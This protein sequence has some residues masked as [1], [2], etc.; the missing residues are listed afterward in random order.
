MKLLIANRGEIALRIQ[1]TCRVLGIPTVAIGSAEE[2]NAQHV[3]QA[4][5]FRIL[6]SGL[7]DSYLDGARVLRAMQ[8]TGADAVHPGY[9]FLSENPEFVELVEGAGLVFVGPTADTMRRLGRKDLAKQL[10]RSL[11][12]PVAKGYDGDDQNDEEFLEHGATIGFPLMV[13]AVSGGGGRGLRR[14]E[15]QS[16]MRELLASA[17]REAQSGFGDSRLL[18]EEIIPAGR[19][20]EVQ[21]LGDGRGNVVHLFERECSVQRR[22][23]KIVE[24][25]PAYRLPAEVRRAILESAI[26]LSREVR[27]RSAATVEFLVF[28]RTPESALEPVFLE[29]NPRLQ[30]EHPVTEEVT[31]YDIVAQQIRIAMG[32]GELPTQDSVGVCGH[33][34]EARIYAEDPSQGFTPS[35]GL[36]RAWLAPPREG[37]ADGLRVESAILTGDEI[38]TSFD[39]MIAKI[40]TRGRDRNEAI[41]RMQRALQLCRIEGFA[42]NRELLQHILSSSQFAEGE[43]DTGWLSQEIQEEGRRHHALEPLALA[44]FLVTGLSQ[45]RVA[46]L[47][48]FTQHSSPWERRDRFQNRGAARSAPTQRYRVSDPLLGGGGEHAARL[49]SLRVPEDSGA[50]EPEFAVIAVDDQE[51]EL[52]ELRWTDMV[53]TARYEGSAIECQFAAQRDEGSA[54][55]KMNGRWFRIS[56]V[57]PQ[58][59]TLDVSSGDG[60]VSS[61]LPG[62][63][64]RVLCDVGDVVEKG[65]PLAILD[66]MKMEHIVSAPRHGRVTAV[67][68]TPGESVRSGE[69]LLTIGTEKGVP[70]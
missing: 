8:E 10:A 70:R 64:V 55:I 59:V 16:E 4:D 31:G 18:I 56:R 14:V 30:V 32:T 52:A 34:I 47:E 7:A 12:V 39:P 42:T 9:G 19:H 43:V 23:Q 68:V 63:V 29:V 15:S 3:L 69:T 33:A 62:S 66:S 60:L 27:L 2:R 6:G 21:M 20:I 28:R 41:Q 65:Q 24:E 26:R 38:L 48:E 51:I 58:S 54:R 49:I 57:F 11:N 53:V 1:R 44:L 40:I 13:K 17:R 45:P 61:P 36:V 22:Y 5:E 25:S 35:G 46:S 67:N 50:L 37:D